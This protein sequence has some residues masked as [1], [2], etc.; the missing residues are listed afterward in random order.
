MRPRIALT[1][2]LCLLAVSSTAPVAADHYD[3]DGGRAGFQV[4]DLWN[5]LVAWV[6]QIGLTI[7]PNG[8]AAPGDAPGT[9]SSAVA[10]PGDEPAYGLTID[11]NG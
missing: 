5:G 3:R 9:G 8:L 4:A 6:A 1:V 2:V 11:P 10:Q 7:D